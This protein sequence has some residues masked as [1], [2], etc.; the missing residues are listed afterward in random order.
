MKEKTKRKFV[1]PDLSIIIPIYNEEENLRPL[2]LELKEVLETYG[3]SFEIIFINDGSKDSSIKILKEFV[4]E[5][6]MNIKVIN[7]EKNCGQ[8]A[9]FDAGFKQAGG[10]VLIT[11]DADMQNDP[12]DIPL[13]LKKLEEYDLVCGWRQKREDSFIKKASSIVA[14]WVRNKISEESIQDT[15]CS[16]KAFR[17]EVPR[18]LKLFSG[19]HRFFPTLAKMEGFSVVEVKVNHR[20][21]IY[22]K[23]K[24]NIRNR[25][26]K[27]FLDLLAVRWMKKR[28]LDYKIKEIVQ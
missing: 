21:R 7:F 27:S 23:S 17:K 16:L 9:A 4:K 28:R 8:T 26:I 19:M 22:G 25:I 10:E 24:Y 6:N 18:H 14:N 5:F 12:R 15:G 13:L 20:P 1:N 3:H 2:T 11:M